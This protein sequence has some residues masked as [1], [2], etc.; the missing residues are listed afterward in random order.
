MNTNVTRKKSRTKRQP[1]GCTIACPVRDAVGQIGDK[2]SMLVLIT[3]GQLGRSR[4]SIIR[5]DI[6]DI[7]QR[8]L[9]VT[10]RALERDGLV[11]RTVYPEIP[12]RVEY[13]LTDLGE[14]LLEP[15]DSLVDWVIEKTPQL[16][17][18]RKAYDKNQKDP[19]PWQTPKL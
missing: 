9:T 14:S 8:M 19:A 12:P 3:L 16:E 18:A 11:S 5:R 4:F 10:L 2:W 7:S 17:K 6:E 15:L 1:P 13:E